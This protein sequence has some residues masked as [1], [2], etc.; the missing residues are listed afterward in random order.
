MWNPGDILEV[1]DD[2]AEELLREP[3][4]SLLKEEPK[5]PKKKTE[6]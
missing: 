4:F 1:A 2:T 5:K 3:G 6:R